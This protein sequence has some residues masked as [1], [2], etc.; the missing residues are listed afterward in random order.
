M[1]RLMMQRREFLAGSAA[2]AAMTTMADAQSLADIPILCHLRIDAKWMAKVELFGSV[3]NRPSKICS[4]LRYW[5]A[6][7]SGCRSVI[8]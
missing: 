7:E 8:E 1:D 2:A 6:A 4:G 5:S 3:V